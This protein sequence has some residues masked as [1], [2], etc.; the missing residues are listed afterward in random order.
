LAGCLQMEGGGV[1]YH[2]EVDA[3]DVQFG[4]EEMLMLLT[5]LPDFENFRVVS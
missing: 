1:V 4:G 3:A 5:L 2:R